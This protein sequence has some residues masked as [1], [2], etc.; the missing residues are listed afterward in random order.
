VTNFGGAANG[1]A[2]NAT[3]LSGDLPF[4]TVNKVIVD[5]A[6]ARNGW[7]YA[8]TDYGPY[9]ST[10]GGVNWYWLGEKQLPIIPVNDMELHEATNT[11]YIGT[12]GRGM[13][14]IN[15]GTVVPVENPEKLAGKAQFLKN[16]PN[17]VTVSTQ[18]K[19]QVRNGQKLLVAL[20]DMKG[21]HVHTLW[22]K[23]AEADK[24]YTLTW[25]RTDNRGAKVEAGQ[26]ILRAI[27]DRVTLARKIEVR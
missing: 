22:D 19:F 4:A 2:A 9:I 20:Y 11:L 5:R 7:L 27:G 18:V 21:R 1:F 12:Y 13:W 24:A 16:F 10:N 6:P 8:A 26:Y 23:K 25:N 3:D 14:S 15:L 17:P